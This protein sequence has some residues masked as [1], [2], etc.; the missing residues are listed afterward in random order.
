MLYGRSQ[1]LPQFLEGK[2]TFTKLSENPHFFLDI[3]YLHETP[4]DDNKCEVSY[5]SLLCIHL[6]EL[7]VCAS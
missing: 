7:H 5:E 4:G 2:T 3:L 6:F 1:C